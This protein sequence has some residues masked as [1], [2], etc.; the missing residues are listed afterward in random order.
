MR[1]RELAVWL[2]AAG[3]KQQ[4]CDAGQP[5]AIEQAPSLLIPWTKPQP[6]RF[7]EILLPVTIERHRVRPIK[8]ERRAALLKSI[9]RGRAWLEELVSGTAT[10]EQPSKAGCPVASA[11]RLCATRRSNGRSSSNGSVWHGVDSHSWQAKRSPPH[12][13]GARNANFCRGD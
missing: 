5:V 11:L 12:L 3:E 6:K 4:E 10:I 9:A 8:F 1:K 2:K 7:K 13:L